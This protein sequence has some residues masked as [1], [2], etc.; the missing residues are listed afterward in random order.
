MINQ[1]RTTTTDAGHQLVRVAAPRLLTGVVLPASPLLRGLEG[2]LRSLDGRNCSPHTLHAYAT[3]L[4]QFLTW[5]SGTFAPGILP[6]EVQRADVEDYLF[7]LARAGLTGRTRARKLAV[8]RQFFRYLKSHG[9]IDASP[10]D[11]VDIPKKELR[12]QVWLHADEYSE[13]IKQAAGKPRDYCILQAFLQTGVRISELCELRLTD[14]DLATKTLH[15]RQG[16]GLVA[17][18]IPLEKKLLTALKTWLELRPDVEDDHLFLNRYGAPIGVRGVRKLITGYRLA[19]GIT[20]Q[21]TPHSFR[22]TFADHK[23]RGGVPLPDLMDWMGHKKL[24]TTQGYINPNGVNK[25][26]LME[27]TSL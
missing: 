3:D 23:A 16:K 18:A 5:L 12:Q 17:R 25:R 27:A 7:A 9:A 13:M 24:A 26:K 4:A 8:I 22:R 19:A 1:A 21:A 6:E 15:V 10:A 11:E 14:L 2:F 20:K